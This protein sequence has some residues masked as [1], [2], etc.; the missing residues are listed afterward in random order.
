[1]ASDE[2]LYIEGGSDEELWGGDGSDE[3]FEE[4]F[5]N[6]SDTE[7]PLYKATDD[8]EEE[9]LTDDDDDDDDEEEFLEIEKSENIVDE[10]DRLT[11][12]FICLE[13]L[14][15][16]ISTRA[17]HIENGSVPLVKIE[18]QDTP[19]EI[20]VRELLEGKLPLLLIRHV[21]NKKEIFD[22]NQM[23]YDVH[24]LPV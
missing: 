22:P 17:A 11:S 4:D 23:A 8:D 15:N 13:E 10:D 5:S 16:L 1:M 21:G 20:A 24:Q 7:E 14:T 2:E 9:F 6:V 12:D 3:D 19:K 18:L